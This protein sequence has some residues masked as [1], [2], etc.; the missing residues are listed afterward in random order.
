MSNNFIKNDPQDN[1]TDDSY[2]YFNEEPLEK[3]EDDEE[4][5]YD[6]DS[7]ERSCD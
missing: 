2:D 4:F 1:N 3:E 5:E 7:D 6:E